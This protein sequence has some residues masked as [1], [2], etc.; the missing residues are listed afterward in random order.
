MPIKT[1]VRGGDTRNQCPEPLHALLSKH[2]HLL[3][4]ESNPEKTKLRSF[5]FP[6]DI[7]L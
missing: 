5:N 4:W 1:Q 6:V 2:P 3:K 7:S